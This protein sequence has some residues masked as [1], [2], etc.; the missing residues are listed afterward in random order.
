[1][2][3]LV[4]LAGFFAGQA[5]ADDAKAQ[6]Y[7]VIVGIDQ[8]KDPQILP[9]KHAEADAKLL[10]DVFTNP[11]YL[12]IDA[13]HVRLFL[14]EKDAKRNSQPATKENIIKSLNWVV[15]NAQKDD[16]VLFLYFGEGA[17]VGDRTCY[18]TVDSTFKDR[19]K[20]AL[21][22]GDIE[23]VLDKLKSQHFCAFIDVNLKGFKAGNEKVTDPDMTKVYRELLGKDDE[24]APPQSRT[25]FFANT[26]MKP[27]LDLK[28]NGIFAKVI[29]DGLKGKADTVGYEADG[30]ITVDE[31]VKYVRDTLPNLARTEGKTDDEKGQTPMV[32]EGHIHD[33]VLVRNPAITAQT[34]KRIRAFEEI[35]K[36][37]NLPKSVVEQGVNYLD[38][39]PKLEAQQNLRKAYQKLADGRA[40]VDEFTKERDSI[41]ESMR[42]AAKDAT[43]YAKTVLSANDTVIQYYYKKL[44]QSQL[45]DLEIHGMYRR[46]DEAV[47]SA[48]KEKLE[49][50]K[51]DEPSREDLQNLL[52]DARIHLGKREDL[53]KGK[54]VTSSLQP[55]FSK[56]DRHSD[57]IDPDLVKKFQ[58]ELRGNFSGIGVQIRK[59]TARDELQVITPIRG[60]PAYKAKMYAGDIITH[61]VREVDDKGK[62]LAEPQ[63]IPTKGLTTQQCVDKIKGLPG[64]KIKLIVEREGE[65]KPLEFNLVRGSVE[66]E[67]VLGYKRNADDSWDYVIDPENQIC[68]IRL[69]QF[70]DNSARDM[71]NVLKELNEQMQK[72]YKSG[73]R[74][75]ILDLRFNPGGLLDQAVKICDL[76]IDDGM[77]VTIKPR[78]GP[79]TSYMAKGK[80][81]YT[82]FPMVCLVNGY[83]ASASEIVSACL[84]DHGRAL[85]VGSRSYGK[86]SVQTILPFE[87]GG[88]LKIT[89]A[90]FWRPTGRNLNKPST[91]GKEEEEWGVKPNRG[92]SLQLS[93][94]ELNDLQDYQR[95]REIINRPGRPPVTTAPADFRDRQLDMAVDYLR[96][97]IRKTAGKTAQK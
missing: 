63:M 43:K 34:R 50:F 70:Q 26:G 78:T 32:V 39:M 66:M 92:Y 30:Y 10:Y 93:Y 40:T 46:T 94:K 83:S 87:T 67:T 8:Y 62:P 45:V 80:G 11:D 47:P 90:T 59:N 89:T 35:A 68:Y 3:V 54:D 36:K 9:R 41:L 20:T 4:L 19:E 86:G 38:H 18:F 1:L 85:I 6:P 5:R 58:E 37:N 25:L 65:A 55:M 95:D 53:E 69:T 13:D 52:S 7:I 72:L 51:H 23:T 91:G 61:I 17:P 77:I 44:T 96:N 82:A 64:T 73:I 16:L 49:K 28:D 15:T 74:G 75:F 48:I 27:S 31:L 60:S 84:Q 71:E 81:S 29:A 79:E 33:Y 2:A 97:E 88:R 12:G 21:F 14:G 42:L 22:A 24:S 57:Y 76:F 56:L